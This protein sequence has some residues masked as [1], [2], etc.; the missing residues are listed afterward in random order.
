MKN[1]GIKENKQGVKMQSKH[2]HEIKSKQKK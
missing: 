1:H 2:Q